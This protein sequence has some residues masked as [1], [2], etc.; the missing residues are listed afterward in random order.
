[1]PDAEAASEL[2]LELAEQERKLKLQNRGRQGDSAALDA[3][4]GPGVEISDYEWEPD[5]ISPTLEDL[6]LPGGNAI[7]SELWVSPH[8]KLQQQR[9]QVDVELQRRQQQ[10]VSW[11][12]ND[13]AAKRYSDAKAVFDRTMSTTDQEMTRRGY[14]ARM[15]VAKQAL[16]RMQEALPTDKQPTVS[17]RLQQKMVQSPSGTFL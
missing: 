9:Q 16:T 2:I 15:Q 8:Q 17:E 10:N 14:K 7:D 13:P 12:E 11:A 1:M 5:A 4:Y 3:L 6:K